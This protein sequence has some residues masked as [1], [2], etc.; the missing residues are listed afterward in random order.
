MQLSEVAPSKY[1]WNES[2]YNSSYY[3]ILIIT[4]WSGWSDG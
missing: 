1:P 4:N 2:I 3:K